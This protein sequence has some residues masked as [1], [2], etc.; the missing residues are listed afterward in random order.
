MKI[1]PEWAECIVC[2]GKG[3]IEVAEP[4]K[5]PADPDTTE[6]IACTACSGNGK[7]RKDSL[8][9]ALRLKNGDALIDTTIAAVDDS[10]VINCFNHPDKTCGA[11]CAAFSVHTD[12]KGKTHYACCA[13]MPKHIIGVLD[14]T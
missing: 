10:N 12:A 5:N 14:V 6:D 13:G 3:T 2:A 4:K 9:R 7:T 1:K 11:L 8:H